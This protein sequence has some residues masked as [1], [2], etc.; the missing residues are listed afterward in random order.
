MNKTLLLIGIFSCFLFHVNAQQGGSQMFTFLNTAPSGYSHSLGGIMI[1]K[2][3]SDISVALQNPAALNEQTRQATLFSYGFN[4][5]GISTGYVAYG[6]Y[7]KKRDIDFHTGLQ[8]A[9][10][11]EFIAADE[12][13]NLNGTFK[14]A[15]Y[16]LVLGATK[17]LN[18]NFHIGVNTKVV[19]SK[20]ENYFATGLAWDIGGIYEMKEKQASLGLSIK[21]LGF[22][23]K[24]YAHNGG[25]MPFDLQLGFSKKLKYIPFRYHITGHHLYKWNVRYNDP[26]L[27]IQNG[28]GEEAE[29]SKISVFADNLFRHLIFGGEFLFGKKE[30]LKVRFAY[31]HMLRREL[32]VNNLRTITGFSGGAE[33]K[34]KQL[35]V[36]YSVGLQHLHGSTKQLT[37][38][39]NINEFRKKR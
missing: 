4:T 39:T 18:E 11:G 30:N 8:F 13:G 19:Y 16:A 24:S 20:L 32:S 12:W 37:I 22:V 15:D 1:S 10:Y 2:A 7:F 28:L 26:A 17:H 25:V 9:N 23:I 36:G 3:G 6:A 38:S 31:N 35:F 5:A 33:F 34:V 21:N 27:V 29:P 14:A